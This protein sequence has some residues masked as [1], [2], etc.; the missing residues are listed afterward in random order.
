MMFHLGFDGFYSAL[1]GYCLALIE[2]LPFSA[3]PHELL[4]EGW[5][6]KITIIRIVAGK[7]TDCGQYVP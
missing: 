2:D 6:R 3:Y 1:H 4:R 7:I 5:I